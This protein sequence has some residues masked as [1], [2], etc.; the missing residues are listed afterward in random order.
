LGFVTIIHPYHPLRGQRYEVVRIRRGADP[1][2]ILRLVD[3]SHAAI[4]LSWTDY[5]S[6]APDTQPS[7]DPPLLDLNGL[8]RAAQLVE[9]MRQEG[10]LPKRRRS[11][12]RRS[13]SPS[14]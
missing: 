14:R 10:R 7:A 2:V 8:R 4:A 5:R 11:G 1:D 3:G 12:P 6:E 13:L 9:H